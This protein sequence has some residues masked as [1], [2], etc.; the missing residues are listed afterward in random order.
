FMGAEF[1]QWSEWSHEGNLEW[2]LL[3]RPE[4]SSVRLL[5]GELN[6][7]Y[8]RE[9]AL[10]TCEYSPGCF[11]WIDFH[12]ADKDIVVFLRK[13]GNE[14]QQIIVVCH[15]SPVPIE[16]YRIGAPRRGFWR[17][18]LNTDAVQYGGSGRGNYGGVRTVP[19]PLHDRNYSLTVNVPPLAVLYFKWAGE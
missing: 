2:P 5:V 18:F 15:F 1:A 17:E 8:R 19:I 6:G 16:N 4:H 10:Y 3:E 7:I 12:D 11:E 9:P 14:D 13:G